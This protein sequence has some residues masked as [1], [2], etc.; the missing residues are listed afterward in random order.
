MYTYNLV[1]F[2]DKSDHGIR[3]TVTTAHHLPFEFQCTGTVLNI[4]PRIISSTE[5]TYSLKFLCVCVCASVRERE[6][7][8]ERERREKDLHQLTRIYAQQ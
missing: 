4:C 6:R 8:G 7:E 2:R 1:F 3:R 5:S